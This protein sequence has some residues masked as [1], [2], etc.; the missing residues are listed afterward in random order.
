MFG[1]TTFDIF[2]KIISP[3]THF[4][5]PQKLEN[6]LVQAKKPQSAHLGPHRAVFEN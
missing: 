6:L 4:S 3:F 5:V 1:S 2:Q